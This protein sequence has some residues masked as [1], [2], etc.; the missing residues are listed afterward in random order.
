[1]QI[2]KLVL[3]AICASFVAGAAAPAFADDW[4]WRHERHERQEARE[5]EWRAHEWRERQWREHEWRQRQRE[6]YGYARPPAY[7]GYPGYYR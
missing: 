3:T 7:Y 2:R 4:R 6:Q 5:R 1:M